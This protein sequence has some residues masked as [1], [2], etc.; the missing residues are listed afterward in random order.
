MIPNLWAFFQVLKLSLGAYTM[1]GKGSNAEIYS[2]PSF[3]I[4]FSDK[5]SLYCPGCLYVAKA[6]F[7]L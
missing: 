4:L 7:E 1:L 6:A 5:I 2:Q 3:Y